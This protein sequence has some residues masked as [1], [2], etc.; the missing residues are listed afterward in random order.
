MFIWLNII[1]NEINYLHLKKLIIHKIQL[2]SFS[3]DVVDA[4]L[5]NSWAPFLI[6]LDFP[7]EFSIGASQQLHKLLIMC[8]YD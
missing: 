4:K 6:L 7:N 1:N 8:D 3:K 5:L 2:L